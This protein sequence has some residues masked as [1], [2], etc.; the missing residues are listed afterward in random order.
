MLLIYADIV[1]RMVTHRSSDVQNSNYFEKC[2]NNITV[3]CNTF[4]HR[5]LCQRCIM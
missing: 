2:I 1:E 4:T 5:C 3:M